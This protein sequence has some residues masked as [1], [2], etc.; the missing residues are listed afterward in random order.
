M[1]SFIPIKIRQS[2]GASQD[3][4][5]NTL[6]LNRPSFAADKKPAGRLTRWLIL[7]LTA[8]VIVEAGAL[9]GFFIVKP[10]L[11]YNNLMPTKTAAVAYFEQTTLR[12]I[13]KTL[14]DNQYAWP[15]F[16]W[17]GETIKGLLTQNKIDSL[18]PLLDLFEDK[19]TLAILPKVSLQ[20][21]WLLFAAKKASDETWQTTIS[22]TETALKQNFNLVS[23]DYRQTTITQIKQLNQTQASLF[24]VLVQN[25]FLASNDLDVLKE[26]I[27]RAI[28]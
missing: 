20:P 1:A 26:T 24:Y 3:E 14:Q 13:T 21:T 17:S 11:P 9:I 8:V 4:V 7:I 6:N 23:E 25:Y 27:D 15:P 2:S 12:N 16:I 28:D 19:I 18:D 22:Q 5:K 10:P